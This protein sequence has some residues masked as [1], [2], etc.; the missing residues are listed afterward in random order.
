MSVGDSE[1]VSLHKSLCMIFLVSL[2]EST[3]WVGV[4]QREVLQRLGDMMRI[5][6]IYTGSLVHYRTKDCETRD[7]PE[8][9]G[10]D[11]TRE[12]GKDSCT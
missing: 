4:S 9:I 11:K 7:Y 2:S 10:K 5:V 6:T 3:L 12:K 8:P 1:S